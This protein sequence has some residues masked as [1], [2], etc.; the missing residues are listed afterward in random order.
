MGFSLAVLI[1]KGFFLFA[2]AVMCCGAIACQP[3]TSPDAELNEDADSL[4]DV[5]LSSPDEDSPTRVY[6]LWHASLAGEAVAFEKA[7]ASGTLAPQATF[8]PGGTMAIVTVRRIQQVV[9]DRTEQRE[10]LYLMRRGPA[11]QWADSLTLAT[12]TS[13][14]YAQPALL[15]D[16]EGR[17]HALF[18]RNGRPA[19]LL[20]VANQV[21]TFPLESVDTEPQHFAIA[22][23]PLSFI[24]AVVGNYTLTHQ[25]FVDDSWLTLHE[26]TDASC[27]D[28]AFDRETTGSG[29]LVF[30]RYQGVG[31][32]GQLFHYVWD[33]GEWR[34]EAVFDGID[35]FPM[36]RVAV[37]SDGRSHILAP[38][39]EGLLYLVQNESTVGGWSIEIVTPASANFKNEHTDIALAG[40]VPYIA[41]RDTRSAKG[42]LGVRND[43]RWDIGEVTGF[44]PG[45]IGMQLAV[46]PSSAPHVVFAGS[47]LVAD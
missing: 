32:A 27:P 12:N 31:D 9:D 35:F 23:G 36:P 28:L 45:F 16:A 19:H 5:G 40:N 33:D 25:I 13:W 11:G 29:R 30:L 34:G 3:S 24:H 39:S 38:S 18:S 26:F 15:A 44:D 4:D 41:Y 14:T 6:G 37:D 43:A 2:V 42:Y 7:P 47:R 10:L 46:D 1:R 17:L 22:Q 20:V 8:M 21:E